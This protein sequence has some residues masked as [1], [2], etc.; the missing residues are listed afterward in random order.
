MEYLGAGAG[1]FS[2]VANWTG[3]KCNIRELRKQNNLTQKELARLVDTNETTISRWERGQFPSVP[4]L[5]KLAEALRCKVDDL[6]T[7]T[8]ES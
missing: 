6:Y 1:I 7:Y 5:W 8:K 3:M 4:A 2:H